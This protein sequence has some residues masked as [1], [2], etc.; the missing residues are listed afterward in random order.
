MAGRAEPA[1]ALTFPELKLGKRQHGKAAPV[2]FHKLFH[3]PFLAEHPVIVRT[4]IGGGRFLTQSTTIL[5]PFS[6]SHNHLSQQL[7]TD[8]V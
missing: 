8:L 2:E 3:Y 5:L 4:Q 6:G 1:S 7:K